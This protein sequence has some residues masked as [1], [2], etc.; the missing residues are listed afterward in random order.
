VLVDKFDEV[1]FEH[2][3][4]FYETECLVQAERAEAAAQVKGQSGRRG[5]ADSVCRYPAVQLR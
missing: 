2:G 5:A 1:L 3:A 4:R